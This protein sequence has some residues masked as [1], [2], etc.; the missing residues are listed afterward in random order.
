MSRPKVGEEVKTKTRTDVK[1]E[2][3][4]KRDEQNWSS[5]KPTEQKVKA[6]LKPVANQSVKKEKVVTQAE[7][8]KNRYSNFDYKYD[9]PDFK[10]VAPEE[11]NKTEQ[12]FTNFTETGIDP[13]DFSRYLKNKTEFFDRDPNYR[14]TD[15]EKLRKSFESD[16]YLRGYVQDRASFLENKMKYAKTDEEKQKIIVEYNKLGQ[17]YAQYKQKYFPDLVKKEEDLKKRNTEIYNRAKSGE[18]N[19]LY[20]TGKV[21]TSFAEGAYK[22]IEDILQAGIENLDEGFKK[23]GFEIGL[24]GEQTVSEGE[25]VVKNEKFE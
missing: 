12:Y 1:V 16:S 14:D 20:Q 5:N 8:D 2:Q 18:G 3:A 13:S 19:A 6:S 4:I 15:S 24:R 9:N 23:I 25:Q 22:P 7:F 11:L 10:N 17:G 21:I